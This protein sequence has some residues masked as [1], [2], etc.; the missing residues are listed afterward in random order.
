MNKD[1]ILCVS[2]S[3]EEKFYLNPKYTSL[4]KSIQE[5]LR[6]MCVMHTMEAGGVLTVSFDD[7]GGGRGL[8]L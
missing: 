2:S 8:Y 3:Y 5:E 6:I 4:P 1:L 7:D